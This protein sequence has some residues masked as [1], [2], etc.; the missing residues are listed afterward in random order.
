[1]KME[2]KNYIMTQQNKEEINIYKFKNNLND[3]N[4][5]YNELNTSI[6]SLNSNH[7]GGASLSNTTN[8]IP[9]YINLTNNDIF[10]IIPTEKFD[11]LN[12]F[13]YTY[14]EYDYLG[15]TNKKE[16]V[17][18][19][20]TRRFV[21]NENSTNNDKSSNLTNFINLYQIL[22][23]LKIDNIG[24]YIIQTIKIDETQ[25][26][27]NIDMEWNIKC[28]LLHLC[29]ILTS[30]YPQTNPQKI[31]IIFKERFLN[32]NLKL[33]NKKGGDTKNNVVTNQD[34]FPYTIWIYKMIKTLY[35]RHLVKENNNDDDIITIDHIIEEQIGFFSFG[36]FIELFELVCPGTTQSSL[37]NNNFLMDQVSSTIVLLVYKYMIDKQKQK[38]NINININH[39]SFINLFP[40]Y[41]FN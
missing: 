10:R 24:E 34:T 6:V 35:Y 23:N 32:L 25:C 21:I 5:M 40:Y 16:I 1:M 18:D 3:F 36:I 30:N 41:A 17:Y 26:V 29:K 22:F 15:D 13:L 8:Y 19:T 28:S 11:L 39:V 2:E 7:E 9:R 38:S 12:E 37:H 27:N 20:F 4:E 33:H 14:L 31:G